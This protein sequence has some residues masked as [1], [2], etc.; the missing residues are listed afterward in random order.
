V[1]FVSEKK[2]LKANGLKHYRH[3]KPVDFYYIYEYSARICKEL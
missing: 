2:R 3:R 1:M